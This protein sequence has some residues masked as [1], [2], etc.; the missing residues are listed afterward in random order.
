M[1]ANVRAVYKLLYGKV[2][3]KTNDRLALWG[4]LLCVS[5]PL[6]GYFDGLNY[7]VMH[8]ILALVFFASTC[9]YA[10]K[11][12]SVLHRHKDQ[13]RASSHCMIDF[14]NG[15]GWAM[16]GVGIVLGIVW[17]LGFYPEVVEWTLAIMYVNYFTFASTLNDYYQSI[18]PL[19]EEEEDNKKPLV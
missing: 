6:I 3:A 19:E 17:P 10:N 9:F 14:L 5:F 13:F 12:S 8:P 11:L 18:H 7:P 2:S 1:Q 15:L 16:L 4:A